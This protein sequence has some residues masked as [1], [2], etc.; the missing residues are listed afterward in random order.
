[1]TSLWLGIRLALTPAARI[2]TT[3]LVLA[4]VLVGVV[5]LTTAA[6]GRFELAHASAYQAEMP[7]LVLAA[8]AAVTLPCA[9]LLA[10]VARLSAALRDRRLANLRLIGLTPTQTRLVGAA[11]TGVATAVGGVVG[12]LL[13][14]AL[15]PILVG[16]PV[17]GRSWDGAF[18][19]A[20]VDQLLVLIG[21]PAVVVLAGLLPTRTTTLDPL[22]IAH[23]ADRTPP[24]WWRLMP[25][26]VGTALCAVVVIQGHQLSSEATNRQVA[27][28]FGGVGLLG[29]GLVLVLPVLVRLL[30][31]ALT[32]RPLG[33]ASRVAIRR[34]EAQPAGVAR[35]VG[36]LLVGLFLVTGA[37][38]VLVAFE[39]TPQYLEA[40]H[41][42]EDG[43]QLTISSTAA[44]ATR[45]TDRLLD[46]PGVRDVVDVP[47][48]D[49]RRLGLQALVATCAELPRL[50]I[51]ATGC[52][53]EPMWLDDWTVSYLRESAPARRIADGVPWSAGAEQRRE[54]VLRTPVDL[55]VI[56]TAGYD[57][58]G[59]VYA[60]AV[61]P[62]ALVGELPDSTRHPLLVSADPGRDL[63]DRLSALGFSVDTYPAYEEYDFV[64]TMR[65]IIWTIAA[66]VLGIGLLAL[67][68][69][70][71]DRAVQRRKEVVALQLIGLSPR[72]LRRAQLL[73]SALPLTIG[74]VL[75]VG[76]GA[77]AGATYLTLDESVGMPWS[78]TWRLAGI[79]VVGGLVV[80]AVC[81]LAATP[82]LR[83]EEIRAE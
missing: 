29:I 57:G 37:R 47:T 71:L 65:T 83:P 21:I 30:T 59:P 82:R 22:A 50:G 12:W 43:Q 14:G 76:L 10:T 68:I 33:A 3:L 69:A 48:L 54:V 46:Q 23:R 26:V 28:L 45:D 74:I 31:R 58:S 63:P 49:F 6:A 34:L 17:A 64:A 73:E 44:T 25:L 77:L 66:V 1:M 80:A 60:D 13:F 36:A 79:G 4:A 72:V 52:R 27:L 8:V 81:M 61:I 39:S 20:P 38:Y 5:A 16:H 18:S 32:G 51:E 2:R 53:D 11:E 24:G 75:S 42:I 19:P 70:T 56:E 9:V 62:P 35:I 40:A 78:Q 67:A 15:R 55:P 7:R 41:N